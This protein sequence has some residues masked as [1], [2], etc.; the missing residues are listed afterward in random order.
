MYS[1]GVHILI[2]EY[3]VFYKYSYKYTNMMSIKKEKPYN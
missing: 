1:P 3:Y 2:I